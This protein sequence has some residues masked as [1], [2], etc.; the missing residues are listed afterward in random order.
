MAFHMMLDRPGQ[1]IIGPEYDPAKRK[2]LAKE[3]T[4]RRNALRALPKTIRRIRA[5]LRTVPRH[6]SAV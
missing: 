4:S 2:E 6:A 1:L 5:A 3:L